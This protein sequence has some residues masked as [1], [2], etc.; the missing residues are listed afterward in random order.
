MPRQQVAA[1]FAAAM[2]ALTK[3]SASD[4]SLAQTAYEY[5]KALKDTDTGEKDG[6]GQSIY[7]SY[8]VNAIDV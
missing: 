1:L 4:V 3:P 8:F 5:V 2:D 7:Q 6:E